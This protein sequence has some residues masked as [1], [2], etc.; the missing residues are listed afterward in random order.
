MS[1]PVVRWTSSATAAISPAPDESVRA[2]SSAIWARL[3]WPPLTA[4]H[5][6]AWRTR[7]KEGPPE[8]ALS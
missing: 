1:M 5:P 3:T 2:P 7:R 8:R 4:A 6:I